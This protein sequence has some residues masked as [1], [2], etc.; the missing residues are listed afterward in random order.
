MGMDPHKSAIHDLHGSRILACQHCC[1]AILIFLSYEQSAFYFQWTT[2]ARVTGHACYDK[3]LFFRN[4]ISVACRPARADS[5]DRRGR[6]P[7]RDQPRTL[8]H[9]RQVQ[10]KLLRQLCAHRSR[11]VLC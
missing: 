2:F 3:K 11:P 1:K 10:R 8:P 5:W 7:H 4:R 9:G 6:D